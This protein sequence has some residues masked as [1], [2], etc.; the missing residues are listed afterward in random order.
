MKK[1]IIFT[2][3]LIFLIILNIFIGFKIWNMIEENDDFAPY[4]EK[5]FSEKYTLNTNL[6]SLT[7]LKD[8]TTKIAQNYEKDIKLTQIDYF[9]EDENS[10]LI[11]LQ[12]YKVFQN[13]PKACRIDMKIDVATK[14]IYNITYQKGHGKRVCG[15]EKEIVETLNSDISTYINTKNITISID[16][17]HINSGDFSK[18]EIEKMR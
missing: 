11:I 10:G 15:L 13:S 2:V 16:N 1:N 14:Q 3:I 17:L 12:F 4:T 8:E 5:T 7:E 9:L 18:S 6:F